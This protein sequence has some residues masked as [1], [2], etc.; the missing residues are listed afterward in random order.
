[1]ISYSILPS[2]LLLFD[3]PPFYFYYPIL[4]SVI[5][6]HLPFYFIL[7]HIPLY[8]ITICIVFHLTFISLCSHLL[9]FTTTF[10]TKICIN[11]IR[12]LIALPKYI[13]TTKQE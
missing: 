6:I 2:L 1:L 13:C 4:F 10:I 7:I 9:S 12:Y 8:L 3:L 11:P 5:V